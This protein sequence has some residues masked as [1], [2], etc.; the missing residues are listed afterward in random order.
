MDRFLTRG[1]GTCRYFSGVPSDSSYRALLGR[2]FADVDD[3]LLI[4]LIITIAGSIGS[5]ANKVK[6][7]RVFV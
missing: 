5:Q 6:F 4:I 1:Q 2:Y 7:T 3:G